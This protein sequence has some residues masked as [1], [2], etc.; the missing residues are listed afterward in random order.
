MTYCFMFLLYICTLDILEIYYT[1]LESVIVMS[2]MYTN[3][4]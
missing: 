3:L 4:I 1:S 2:K